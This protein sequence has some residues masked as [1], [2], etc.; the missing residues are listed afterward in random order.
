MN[1]Y[2]GNT[3]LPG[4]PI[5]TVTS[6]PVWLAALTVSAILGSPWALAAHS[7]PTSEFRVSVEQGRLSVS[8]KN[9]LL[10]RVLEELA[11]QADGRLLLPESA[12]QSTISAHLQDLPLAVVIRRLLRR[13]SYI[14][15]DGYPMSA[16]TLRML[17]NFSTQAGTTE[18][19]PRARPE[20]TN[21]EAPEAQAEVQAII[22]PL[23]H[24]AKA[25]GAAVKAGS[26]IEALE[27]LMR[28]VQEAVTPQE[29][30]AAMNAFAGQ[31]QEDTTKVL[32]MAL[33]KDD[34][35]VRATAL[36]LMEHMGDRAPVMLLAEMAVGDSDPGIRMRALQQLKDTAP[37]EL[38][39][40]VE[41]SIEQARSAQPPA[42]PK[43]Q[44]GPV[45]RQK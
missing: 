28:T 9:V 36:N 41:I 12:A 6:K 33:S 32:S 37:P 16:W 10:R 11:L 42:S 2:L 29:R 38:V 27:D 40:S 21:N 15:E 34:P 30:D 23:Q 3:R 13:E 45:I 31:D 1:K 39:E 20:P 22:D 5:R 25:D 35:Q 14:L 8:V 44:E 26:A 4:I 24:P 17:P 43:G 7:E 19:Q 18:E